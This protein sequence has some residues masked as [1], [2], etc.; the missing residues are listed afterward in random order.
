MCFE[1][2]VASVA[3]G[4]RPTCVSENGLT[5]G[6]F[7]SAAGTVASGGEDAG[8]DILDTASW[9]T[10]PSSGETPE[11]WAEYEETVATCCE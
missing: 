10:G 7:T 9:A 4:L 5:A 11:R 8:R 1:C 6:F 3:A 2:G